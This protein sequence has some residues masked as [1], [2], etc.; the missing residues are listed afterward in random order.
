M[1]TAM[2]ILCYARPVHTAL[3]LGF[4]YANKSQG[5]D[6]HFFYGIPLDGTH[7]SPAL[8]NMLKALDSDGHGKLHYLPDDA[9]RNTGG[10]VDNLMNTLGALQGHD[11]Y[12]KV[13]DDVIIGPGTDEELFKLLNSKELKEANVLL[14]AGQAAREHM[15]GPNAFGWDKQVGKRTV[16]CRRN[17]LS[18]METYTAV[19]Y[20]ML[21]HLEANG[22]TTSCSNPPGTFGPYS[23]RLWDSGAKAGLVLFP[24][25]VMQ[26]IGLTCTTGDKAQGAARSWAPAKCWSPAGRVIKVPHFDFSVWDHSHRN[27]TQKAVALT[28]L[29]DL[30]K[31]KPSKPLST[32]IEG[33]E[34]YIPGDNDVPLPI[35]RTTDNT[36]QARR[37]RRRRKRARQN[38]VWH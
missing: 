32:V 37:I 16:V 2:G 25:I 12:F 1:H 31:A 29:R 14:L 8:L 21:P 18:P 35:G 11:C 4:A 38:K 19:S 7:K 22:F 5:T 34:A 6:L 26:H 36:S 3:T 15:L 9:E 10:N 24:H 30:Q 20:K 13:D 33:L 27:G 28:M 23:K 17:G